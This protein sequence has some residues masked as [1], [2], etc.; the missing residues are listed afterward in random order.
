[1]SKAQ[2]ASVLAKML[3]CISL[4]L[5]PAARAGAA[6]VT[7]A[8]DPNPETDLLGYRIHYG[9]SSG[10]YGTSIEVGLQTTYTVTGLPAGNYY[11]AI[12]A[13]N[14][15]W[16]ESGYSNEVSAD[17][18]SATQ[19]TLVFPHPYAANDLSP[20]LAADALL[21][22]AVANLDNG[23]ATLSFTAFG[24]D[25][26][27]VSGTNFTNPGPPV[28]EQ[29]GHQISQIDYEL[30]YPEGI[31][32]SLGPVGWIRMEA[33]VGKVAGFFMIFDSRI[34]ILDGAVPI[35]TPMTSAILPEVEDQGFTRV[36]V[37]NP[38]LSAG[39]V[40]FELVNSSGVVRES[41]SLGIQPEGSI[42][43]DLSS[44]LFPQI[45]PAAS[46]YVR[47]TSASGVLPLEILGKTSKYVAVLNAQDA[48]QG[49][50]TLYCPQYAVGG[51]WRSTLSIVNHDSLPGRVILKLF[52]NDGQQIGTQ[53]Q[54]IAANGKLYVYDPAFFQSPPNG[55]L[56]QGWVEIVSS[57]IHIS[58]S[59]VFSDAQRNSYSSAIPLTTTLERSMVFSH[60]ASNTTYYTGI[61]ILNP[62]ST[63][64]EVTIQ[65]YNELG[66]LKAT[67]KTPI[68]AGQRVIKLLPQLFPFMEGQD[69]FS[70]YVLV[71]ADRG[72]SAFA[73]FGTHNLTALS[74]IPPQITR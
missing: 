43:T 61:S 10:V 41:Q 25:G 31:S 63:A 47:V 56:M 8:W 27:K 45:T 20:A 46:D 37:V 3:L 22:L 24:A 12:T 50:T 69:W 65:V 38:S 26:R 60:I 44:G 72:V 73:L 62:D 42:T 71:N 33:S 14:T 19:A 28:S 2:I 15:S 70:G 7:L 58:G 34:S 66:E 6:I 40:R 57:G 9:T 5:I 48:T 1:M 52:G 39:S 32:G 54:Q 18:T 53:D 64:A 21:G 29:M 36:Q 16:L 4:L 35:T 49:A 17:L 51:G 30:F 68:G 55:A 23:D 67:L 13:Y 74:A 11:F 59:V